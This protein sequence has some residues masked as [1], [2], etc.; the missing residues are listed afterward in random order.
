MQAEFDLSD[1]DALASELAEPSRAI[2]PVGELAKH[3]LDFAL[4]LGGV[5]CLL[6][7]L[8]AVAV[9]IK[10]DTPGPVFFRQKRVGRHGR[11]F[12][13]FKFRTM[14]DGAYLMG[15]RLTV[16]RDPR[17]TR[18][19]KFLRWSKLDELPQLFN[20]LSGDM[21]LI[22]PRP[23]DPHFVAYYTPTQRQVL[24]VRPGIVGPSQI[25]GR[26]EVEDYPEGIMDT[27]TYY[28]EH[29]LPPKLAR[30]LEYVLNTTFW[31][32]LKLLVLGVWITV[33]GAFRAEYLWNRRRRAAMMALDV[34]LIAISYV[35]ACLI[36]FDFSW[37]AGDITLR[38]L[39]LMLLLRPPMLMYFGSYHVILSYFGLWDM[40]ALFKAVS[41]GSL[42]VA[43]LTYFVGLQSHPRSV[44][45]I[46]WALLLSLLVG[47][48]YA[49]R[50]WARRHPRQGQARAKAIVVGA[51]SGGEQLLRSLVEDPSTSYRAIGFID[52]AQERWGSRIHGVKVL[53][54]PTELK[55]ALSVN[56]V[57]VVFVC[58]SDLSEGTAHE[59][60]GIC[61]DAG[62]DCRMLPALSDLLN[63]DRYTLK[64]ASAP[65]QS[66]EA[67]YAEA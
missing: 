11:T 21:N 7:L 16:K 47:S 61:S 42:L 24:C 67:T 34:A 15:S 43:A 25:Q 54:G 1:Q 31:G 52:E 59:V 37:H 46:D 13:I 29:I 53:G 19:G 66:G 49:L 65:G 48:R 44:F 36:R 27:E 20:V 3:C 50:A 57:Q 5:I 60:A 62:V 17:V 55:L 56:G 23:E 9:L 39:V 41:A 6:P 30:D 12:L 35:L 10:F 22:G 58:L 8:I 64:P 14:V 51:G 26:N 2:T 4:A 40:F 32:D 38:A 33:R 18:L 63:T 28:R 45:V